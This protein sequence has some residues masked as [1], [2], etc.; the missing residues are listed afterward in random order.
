MDNQLLNDFRLA[1][2]TLCNQFQQTRAGDSN[3]L[4]RTKH[5]CFE[6]LVSVERVCIR[7]GNLFHSIPMTRFV[8]EFS[9]IPPR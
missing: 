5:S 6:F 8:L 3:T 9:R 4:G 1:Y 2:R 7:T